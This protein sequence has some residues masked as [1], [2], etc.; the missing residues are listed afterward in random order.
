MK[1]TRQNDSDENSGIN[2]SRR[3]AIKWLSLSTGLIWTNV[4]VTGTAKATAKDENRTPAQT[5]GIL[6]NE[7]LEVN[8]NPTGT[9]QITTNNGQELT[10]PS[11]STSGLTI[12]IDDTNYSYGAPGGSFIDQYR[13]QDTQ[14]SDSGTEATTKWEIDGVAITQTIELSGEAAVFNLSIENLSDV[15]KRVKARW[16]FDYQVGVQDGAPIFVNGQV[17]TTETRFES[18]DFDTFQT[19][20]SIPDPSL[21]GQGGIRDTPTKIEFVAWEDANS[22]EYQ[23]DGFDST[24][25]FF[26]EGSVNS[27]ASDSAGLIYYDLGSINP[28]TST[29]VQTSYGTGSPAQTQISDIEQA[30]NSFQDSAVN[31]VTTMVNQRAKAHAAIYSRVGDQYADLYTNY[32]GYKAGV[33]DISREDVDN[34]IRTKL[35]ELL[36]EL[37]NSQYSTLYE[38]FNAMFNAVDVSA[39]Q[40][41]MQEVF[42]DFIRG[43]APEQTAGSA[44]RLQFG[45]QSVNQIISEFRSNFDNRK[46]SAI[47]TLQ[48][49][50]LD[51]TEINR[52]ASYYNS[53]GSQLDG[54]A[55]SIERKVEKA[56]SAIKNEETGRVHAARIETDEVQSGNPRTEQAVITAFTGA[57]VIT[58]KYAG[59]TAGGL[60]LSSL[61][62]SSTTVTS[63]A[64]IAGTYGGSQF[65]SSFA[66]TIPSMSYWSYLQT[67]FTSLNSA[68]PSIKGLLKEQ[69][70]QEFGLTPSQII[71]DYT[72]IKVDILLGA[73]DPVATFVS[74]RTDQVQQLAQELSR[75]V[76][77]TDVDAPNIFL[78]DISPEGQATATASVEI[79]NTSSE[80]ITPTLVKS[81]S[82][83]QVTTLDSTL[84]GE[85]DLPTTF[86]A[87]IPE[88]PAGQTETAQ[89]TYE[90]PANYLIGHYDLNVTISPTPTEGG[91]NST[92]SDPFVSANIPDDVTRNTLIDTNISQGQSRQDIYS[93]RASGEEV[94]FNLS[95]LG[96]NLDLHIYDSSDNHVGLDYQTGEFENEIQGATASGPDAPGRAAESVRIAD[97][98]DEYETEVIAIETDGDE[99]FSVDA[100]SIPSVPPI[101]NLTPPAP[102]D[103]IA[104][105]V[106][107]TSLTVRESGGSSGLTNVTISGSEFENGDAQNIPT[108]NISVGQ[109]EFDVSPGNSET[110]EIVVA[111]PSDAEGTYNGDIQVSSTE[112][113]ST[114]Q[115]AI[116]VSN[117]VI[118]SG[119]EIPIEFTSPTGDGERTVTAD[120]AT[121]AVET[122][123]NGDIS[124]DVA[125][126][127][128]E[129][130]ISVS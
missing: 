66:W 105:T 104:G 52:I 112:T 106:V 46:T 129:V 26:T 31:A 117:T 124:A 28:G 51:E 92:N 3:S 48:S 63:T 77:V 114:A 30:M 17:V 41:T 50:P 57:V 97:P 15:E 71:E 120:D 60:Y 93:S 113:S 121:E 102:Q 4:A 85:R 49:E 130:F 35:D 33:G 32:F 122:F 58:A 96:S 6:S 53:K 59:V 118:V 84:L 87:D 36:G 19:Y 101:I 76:Q 16:L 24:K 22:T 72:G 94:S 5:D 100:T 107:T 54:R 110:V 47:E 1:K 103:V 39:D 64:A 44:P 82:G 91:K 70:L 73:R 43:E 12:Q 78:D 80:P 125:V 42:V 81:N 90:F 75:S 9:W 79:K 86:E 68:S 62:Y 23:Y 69:L 37:S 25:S 27:P 115:L 108:E 65:V 98:D 126:D 40:S 95:Y 38:F 67:V 109:S 123:I 128:I 74:V 14:I 127:V 45:G 88:I 18:P 2:T 20:D 111:I 119:Q 21:T 7:N 13:T 61:A 89:I 11:A 56:I 83:V 99:P 34:E 55:K 8:V 116:S 29:S 10:F